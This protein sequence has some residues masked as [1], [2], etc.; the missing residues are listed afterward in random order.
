MKASDL[1]VKCLENE[2][3][4]YIFGIPGEET[5]DLMESLRT[6]KIRFIVTRHEQA[7][8]FMADAYGRLTGRAGV[9]LATLGPGAT[10]LLTGVAD[11]YLDASPVVAITGQADLKR[12]HKESHQYINIVEMCESVTKW[13]GRIETPEVIPEMVRKAFKLAEA[14]KPGPTHLELPE[15]IAS[16]KVYDMY[17]AMI[18]P[19]RARRSSPDR[20]SLRKAA[21]L[22]EAAEFPVILAGHGVVRK[23]A[24]AQLRQFAELL[25]IP[26]VTT[27][28]GK[29]AVSAKSPSCIGAIGLANDRQIDDVFKR[30]DLVIAVGY[31][32]VEYAPKNWN[33]GLDKKIIHMDFTSS[34]VDLHY[35]PEVEIVSDIRES[36]ELLEGMLSTNKKSQC[37]IDLHAGFRDEFERI[38]AQK[39]WPIR[40]PQVLYGIRKMLGDSDILVSDVGTCKFWAAKFY[41][42]Y[43]NNTFILSNG[44]ASMGFSLPTAMAAKLVHPERKIVALSGDGGFLMNLQ[45]LETAVRMKLGMAIVV[46][47]DRGYNLIKWKSTNKFGT[48]YGVDFTNP[49]FIK[50][51]EGFG[52]V[53]LRLTKNDDFAS[54]LRDAL[55]RDVPVIIDVPIDYSDNELIYKLL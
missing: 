22:I 33:P 10:N 41:P 47:N 34:E 43:D 51:A 15:N 55:T 54:L 53:G 45:D 24:N 38:G 28:M 19:I 50:V 26:V 20:Q 11:A 36:V 35:V 25:C 42:V 9:C 18:P 17:A 4:E 31:G 12:I 3:V 49:D 6:S 23:G 27:F 48:S 30:A 16:M 1:L 13:N 44:F 40:P 46:F 32:L 5:L 2:D 39:T 37:A 8:A 21:D 7:A 14:E 52:A 29:G